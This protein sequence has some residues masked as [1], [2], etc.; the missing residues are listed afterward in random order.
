MGVTFSVT[1]LGWS[2]EKY[3]VQLHLYSRAL[4]PDSDAQMRQK[5]VIQTMGQLN[6]SG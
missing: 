6:G 2:A 4:N 3:D 1:F 5:S